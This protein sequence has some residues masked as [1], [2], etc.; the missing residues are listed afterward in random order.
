LARYFSTADETATCAGIAD[1]LLHPRV[2]TYRIDELLEMVA[3]AGLRPLLFAHHGARERVPEEIDRLR[4]LEKERRSPGNFTLYL[5]TADILPPENG[6]NCLMVLNSC[7]I[8]AVSRF[9]LGTVHIPP[10]IGCGNTPLRSSERCFLRQFITPVRCSILAG[11]S[12][13]M[14]DRYKRQLFLLEY[15]G[16]VVRAR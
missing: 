2:N 10:R 8:S 1:A 13:P 15:D 14:T 6:H 5:G 9:K 4:L 11:D 3:Q 7:L 12:A 16:S